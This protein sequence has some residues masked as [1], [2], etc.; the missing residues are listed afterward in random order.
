MG[1]PRSTGERSPSRNDP[2][3]RLLRADAAKTCR[4]P[5][6]V[7]IARENLRRW[8]ATLQPWPKALEEWEHILA[9]PSV[10]RIV[11]ALVADDEEGR[12]R[13]QSSPFAG[14]LSEEE[15]LAVFREYETIGT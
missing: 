11:D 15:R 6:L 9:Q 12:R 3:A 13:R 5:S 4:D 7:D 14:V 2:V 10:D 1:F 8:R